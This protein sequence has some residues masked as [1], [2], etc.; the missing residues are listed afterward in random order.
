MNDLVQK[1]RDNVDTSIVVSTIT[2]TV[3]I[4]LGVYAMRKAGLGSAAKIVTA[5]K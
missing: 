1:Y 5:G 4:G 3:L 2:A